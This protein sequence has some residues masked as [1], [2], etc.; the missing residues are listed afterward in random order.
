MAEYDREALLDAM[1]IWEYLIECPCEGYLESVKRAGG[2]GMCAARDYVVDR[3]L[4]FI[5]S[6]YTEAVGMGYCGAFDLEFV[7]CFMYTF[8]DT[9]NDFWA[10]VTKD[11]F[12]D[13]FD[14]K[15][16]YR[17][18]I[19]LQ[20][21]IQS[22]ES[23]EYDATVRALEARSCRWSNSGESASYYYLG[24]NE[25]PQRLEFTLDGAIVGNALIQ[26]IK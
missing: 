19:S 21:S 25:L 15:R 6:H 17:L 20:G 4:P 14:L 5:Q 18:T 26:E 2:E 22:F 12:L 13:A 8:W 10:P 1:A 7:P 24:N 3:M 16:K 23:F 11:K 9:E